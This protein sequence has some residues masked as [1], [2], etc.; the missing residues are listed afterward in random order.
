MDSPSLYEYR[1]LLLSN[2]GLYV[3]YI[4]LYLTLL[5]GYLAV[6]FLVAR[7]LTIFQITL[8]SLLYFVVMIGVVTLIARV[9]MRELLMQSQI[10]AAYG[11]D[12]VEGPLPDIGQ[13][14]KFLPNHCMMGKVH[15]GIVVQVE[16]GK[17]RI[18]CIDLKVWEHAM[19]RFQ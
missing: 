13:T 9:V 6:A 2:E 15:S 8:I 10:A 16:D 3:Q 12:A 7:K 5:S 4:A 17:T 19:C 1:D 14:V 18:D 11:I